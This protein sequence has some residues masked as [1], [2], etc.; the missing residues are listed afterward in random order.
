MQERNSSV[1]APF[2]AGLVLSL[3]LG[4]TLGAGCGG[5]QEPGVR[6]GD[7][8]KVHY[9][10]KL[11]DGTLFDQSREDAPLEFV[12]GSRDVIP[13]FEKAVLGMETGE[14][15]QVTIKP[16]EAY[17]LKDE[18]M[19]RKFGRDFFPGD[20]KP[21]IGMTLRL[22]DQSGREVPGT[23]KEMTE[24]SISLDLNH[25]LAGKTLTFTLRVVEIT[26]LGEGGGQ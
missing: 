7:K 12:V 18:S 15:K 22:S 6:N 9:T 16:E 25:P 26:P 8:V 1:A 14:E 21:E 23:V 4:L 3:V 13:G 2:R 20:F 17:G 19:V 5:K 10:G 11:D 24:D